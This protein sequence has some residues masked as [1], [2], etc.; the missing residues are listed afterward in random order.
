MPVCMAALAYSYEDIFGQVA[1]GAEMSPAGAP[2]AGS[3]GIGTA[4]ALGIAAGAVLAGIV[5]IMAFANF[6]HTRHRVIASTN[7]DMGMNRMEREQRRRETQAQRLAEKSGYIGKASF[8]KGD[9]ISITSVE[10]WSDRLVAK[11]WYRLVSADSALLALEITSTNDGGA[12]PLDTV[13]QKEIFKGRGNFTLTNYHSVP[14]L[15]HVSMY[16]TDSTNGAFAELYF[17]TEAEAEAESKMGGGK[18]ETGFL[19]PATDGIT[20]LESGTNGQGN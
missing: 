12:T 13:Q 6:I 14:G 7:V 19:S 4:A 1:G 3:G 9:S 16:P 17:G 20:N 18:A 2:V 11:G 10:R 8:P 5:A 15:P